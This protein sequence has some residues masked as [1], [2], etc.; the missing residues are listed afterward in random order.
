MD[1]PPPHD[2]SR[3][4]VEE[5]I[6]R[7]TLGH[8]SGSLFLI[9]PGPYPG[10]PLIRERIRE[11]IAS[12]EDISRITGCMLQY[13]DLL[14]V[15]PGVTLP[16]IEDLEDLISRNYNCE[17][18]QHK[19]VLIRTNIPGTAGSISSLL[20]RPGRPGWTLVI[21]M[22]TEGPARVTS[23]DDLLEW[24]D[25]ARAEIHGLFDFVVPE[26]IVQVIR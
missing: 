8:D 14:P 26:E 22:Y 23:C 1:H 15:L 19:I 13:T 11:M 5:V 24:F 2:F 12:T 6:C 18:R 17:T 3:S 10:W 20:N 21:S 7:C 9:I 16:G 25:D 4:P